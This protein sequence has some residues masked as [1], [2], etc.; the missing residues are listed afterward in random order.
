MTFDQALNSVGLRVRAGAQ[1]GA[2]PV[3]T[4]CKIVEANSDNDPHVVIIPNGIPAKI[5]LRP[6]DWASGRFQSETER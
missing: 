5:I 4:I 6:G 2:F 1:F 3:G